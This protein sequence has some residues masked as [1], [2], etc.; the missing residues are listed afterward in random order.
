MKKILIIG[1]G[2]LPNENTKSRPA[3]GLRTWQFFEGLRGMDGVKV[4]LVK[5]DMPECYSSGEAHQEA[6][7]GVFSVMKDDPELVSKVQKVCDRVRPDVLIGVNTYPSYIASRLKT[8]AAFW[9][10]LNGWIMAEGQ[11][12]AF[13]VGNDDYLAHYREMEASVVARADKFS[14]VSMPQKYALIGELA[15]GGRLNYH[16]FDY[17]LV[18]VVPNGLEW[19]EGEKETFLG[20][21]GSAGV[22]IERVFQSLPA[23]AVKALWLGGYNTWMDEETLFSALEKAMA[24]NHNLYFISTGGAIAG[25]DN[26]TF[27]NF[28]ARVDGSK[29]KERFI[30]M[31]WVETAKIPFLYGAADFGL[32]VDLL[33]VETL[34]GARNRL[35]EMM[36]FGLPVVTTLGSEIADEVQKCGAGVGVKSGDVEALSAAMVA[37]CE[38][39][40]FY[41]EKGRAYIEECCNYE[42]T[43]KPVVKWL[44]EGAVMAPDRNSRPNFGKSGKIKS[45]F[46]YLKENGFGKFLKKL[47]QRIRMV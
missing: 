34:T 16:T 4:E 14:T 39:R 18:S 2:P 43:L 23:G 19:F 47:L 6:V 8:D 13:K 3:A 37:M 10:D 15:C 21:V 32:N 29:F 31:G 40:E 20:G 26:K 35:N 28:K 25:L 38:E 45:A 17:E 44:R 11:A 41:G 5:I 12:Q 24:V 9:A 46:R 22:A 36:K 7:D 30:F 33:C 27:A 42:V 1:N